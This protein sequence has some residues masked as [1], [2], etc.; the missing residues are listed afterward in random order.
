MD[1][2]DYMELDEDTVRN[3]DLIENQNEAS[4]HHSLFTVLNKCQTGIGKRVLKNKILFP[5]KSTSALELIW[6]QIKILDENKKIKT[7]L[8]EEL[9]EFADI[10]RIISRFRGGKGL[11]RDFKTILRT[12]EIA[13][14]IQ[15]VLKTID[16]KFT[17]PE[18]S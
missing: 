12:I 16:Y 15:S 1:D 14:T 3:L 9:S 5:T 7:K 11:P 8:I 13:K 4:K 10:E 6:S 17:I 2:S 18:K